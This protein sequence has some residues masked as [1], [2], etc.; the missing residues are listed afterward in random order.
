MIPDALTAGPRFAAFAETYCQ[1]TK[2][3]WAGKPVILEGWQREPIWEILEIDPV[4]GLRIYREVLIG[5]PTKNGKSLIASSFGLYFLTADGEPEPEVYVGAAARGQAGIVLGQARSMALRSP[6]LWPHVKVQAHRIIC[7]MNGGIMRALSSD[8]G[9]QH[10]LNPSAAIIDELHAHKS[11]DLY[12]VL[13]KSGAAR[14][15]PITIS[16]STSGAD[17]GGVLGDFRGLIDTGPGE[18]E[19]RDGLTIYRDRVNGVLIYWWGADKD[20]DIADPKVWKAVNP[21]SWLQDGKWLR[22]QYEKLKSR[23]KLSEWRMYHLNQT[24]ES[25]DQWMPDD[26][27]RDAIGP[28]L[29]KAHLPTYVCVRIAHDHRSASVA[30]AQRQGESI[31]LNMRQ[32]PDKPLLEGEF[33]EAEHIERYLIELHRRYPAKIVADVQFQTGKISKREKQGPEVQHHGAF[34]ESSRQRL[35]KRGLVMVEVP[36]T[37]E[38]VTPAAETLMQLITSGELE[39]DGDFTTTEQMARVVARPMPKG[40]AVSSGD[41]NPITAPQAAMLAVHRALNVPNAPSRRVSGL[42]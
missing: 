23:G 2:G 3:R 37:H 22:Q 33:V 7:P 39:H 1:H 42:S 12:T 27:W 40:W 29:L 41:G 6:R 36:S 11:A 26:L 13:T 9:L 34:F 19:R 35:E 38:R 18:V 8:A 5:L 24:V 16:I 4:T 20:A 14:E 32:F 10:G 31:I 25:F 17:T 30:V 15:Q 21:A 28:A